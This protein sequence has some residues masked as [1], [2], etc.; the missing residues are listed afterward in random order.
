LGSGRLS[1][2]KVIDVKIGCFEIWMPNWLAGK[3]KFRQ[4]KLTE[5]AD[6]MSDA[7]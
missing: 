1:S 5:F 3:L 7:D 6:V 4:T 2:V